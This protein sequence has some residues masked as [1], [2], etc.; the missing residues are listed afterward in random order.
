METN[1]LGIKLKNRTET[2]VELQDILTKY[3]CSIRSR[4]G[5]HDNA[6]GEVDDHGIILL[7]LTGDLSEQQNLENALKN[8]NGV[9]VQ[10][11]GFVE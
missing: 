8:L 10:K 3:G 11:M 1:I 6:A 7:E 2:A 9:Q 4:I 5:L